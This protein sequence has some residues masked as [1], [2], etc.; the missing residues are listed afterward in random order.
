M[1]KDD[2][3]AKL[4]TY[5]ANKNENTTGKCPRIYTEYRNVRYYDLL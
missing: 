3:K 5:F 4:C 1:Q 2:I